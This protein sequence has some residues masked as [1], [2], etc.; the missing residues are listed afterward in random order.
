MLNKLTVSSSPHI[1]LGE[2]TSGIMLDVIIALIPAAIYGIILFGINAAL[3]VLVSVVS[4]MLS[5]FIWN[6]ILKKENSWFDLSAAVT[7]LILGLCL[8]PRLPIWMAALGSAIAIIVVKQMF[9]G[10]GQNFANPA[11]T[12]RIT[13]MVSFPAAMTSFYEPFGNIVSSAT[14]LVDDG[15][16]T[17]KEFLF[18]IH[19][20]CI[21]EVA[22]LPLIIG[23]LY[24]MARRI[25]SPIIPTSFI[26]TVFVFSW[27]L[28]LNPLNAILS[29]GLMLGAF[30][31]ATDYVTTPS[32]NL[33]KLI[34]G[35]GCGILTVVIRRFA[36]LPEGVSYAILIMNLLVGYINKLTMQ[37]PFFKEVKQK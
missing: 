11:S 25:I 1:H 30:F 12:A 2:R 4:A 37:K 19:G 31:M 32:F 5:E 33:G 13:L 34:F 35:V 27:V 21:G 29:G 20:G 24:L 36:A 17:V 22:I 10:L 28:G 23:G 8:P 26:A 18:G 6:K 15:A 16:L 7:G 14:P 9:G 3:V